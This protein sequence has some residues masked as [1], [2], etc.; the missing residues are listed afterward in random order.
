MDHLVQGFEGIK[1]VEEHLFQVQEGLEVNFI[2]VMQ[3]KEQPVND[4]KSRI[5]KVIRKNTSRPER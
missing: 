1:R 3:I 5:E 4:A 2:S